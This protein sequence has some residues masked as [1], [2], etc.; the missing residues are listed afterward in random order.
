[1][2]FIF[3]WLRLS[4]GSIWPCIWAHGVWNA[5]IQAAFDRSTDGFSPWVGESGVFTAGLLILFA[6][7]VYR[8]WPLKRDAQT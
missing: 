7:A 3:A 5:V 4:S 1:M 8:R 2:G 6:I